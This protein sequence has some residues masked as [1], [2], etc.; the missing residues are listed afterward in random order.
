MPSASSKAAKIT[1]NK[2][3][4]NMT[5]RYLGLVCVPGEYITKIELEEF[6]SQVKGNKAVTGAGTDIV[7]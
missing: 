4:K 2:V 6:A 3:V 1:A 5:A 7:I